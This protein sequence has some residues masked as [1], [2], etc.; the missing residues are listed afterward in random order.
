M[1]EKL[2]TNFRADWYREI[3]ESRGTKVWY[4]PTDSDIA[5]MKQKAVEELHKLL[6]PSTSALTGLRSG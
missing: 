6:D 3:F 1:L 4:F 2:R 5:T